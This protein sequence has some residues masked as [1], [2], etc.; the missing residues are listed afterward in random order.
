MKGTKRQDSYKL[1]S[2]FKDVSESSLNKDVVFTIGV[3]VD[4]ET[5][6]TEANGRDEAKQEFGIGLITSSGYHYSHLIHKNEYEGITEITNDEFR[7][8]TA[9]THSK[10]Q[11]IGE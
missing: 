6:A 10:F 8:I 7:K 9:N 2:K 4:T 5:I 3:V 11:Y 1:G